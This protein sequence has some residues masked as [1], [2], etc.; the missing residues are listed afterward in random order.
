M[1]KVYACLVVCLLVVGVAFS[2]VRAAEPAPRQKLV[3][4][5]R[6]RWGMS[7]PEASAALGQMVV[8]LETPGGR[9][10]HQ[11]DGTYRGYRLAF[12]FFGNHGLERV[13]LMDSGMPGLGGRFAQVEE[14]LILKYGEPFRDEVHDGLRVV[15]W[16]N[17]TAL[18]QLYYRP[19]SSGRTQRAGVLN[20]V[21]TWRES[22]LTQAY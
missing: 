7:V 14:L 3:A 6:L 4:W 17:P 16:L 8:G 21:Y 20:V 19:E 5:D 22:A 1:G 10:T 9:F 13:A 15:W 12:S 18:V 11:I 2:C